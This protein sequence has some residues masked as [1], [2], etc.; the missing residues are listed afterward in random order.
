[1]KRTFGRELVLRLLFE[2][3]VGEQDPQTCMSY[4]FETT[5]VEKDLKEFIT[6]RVSGTLEH[7]EKID[8]IIKKYSKD[9]D[10]DRLAYV[11][12][13]I[14]RMSLFEMNYVDEVPD[15]VTINEAVELAKKY[16][17]ISSGKFIN[18]VL[19]KY[20][21]TEKNQDKDTVSE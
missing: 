7:L 12:K 1:M 2:I 9:W 18:G 20:Y 13:A 5:P 11:D 17:D 14:L 21:N 19:G 10:I 3:E 4:F 6:T 8:E 15:V 16:S